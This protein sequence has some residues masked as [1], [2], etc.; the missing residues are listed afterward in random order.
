MEHGG[1]PFRAKSGF[2][3]RTGSSNCAAPFCFPCLVTAVDD[4]VRNLMVSSFRELA[5]LRAV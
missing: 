5:H 1:R 2:C 4:N 3:T